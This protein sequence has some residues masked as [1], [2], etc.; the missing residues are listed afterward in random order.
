M[1]YRLILVQVIEH[2]GAGADELALLNEV[3]ESSK[4]E[5]DMVARVAEFLMYPDE[6]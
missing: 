5:A 2:D 6:E 1:K 4:D 3:F